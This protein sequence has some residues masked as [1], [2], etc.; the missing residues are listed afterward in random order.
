M[1]PS[2]VTAFPTVKFGADSQRPPA[3]EESQLRQFHFSLLF[4]E[5][6]THSCAQGSQHITSSSFQKTAHYQFS[7]LFYD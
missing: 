1:E 2:V 3:Q 5:F 6:S 7:F 4:Y